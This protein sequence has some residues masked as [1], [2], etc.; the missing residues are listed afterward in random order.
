M[1]PSAMER[2]AIDALAEEHDDGLVHAAP[3]VV[4]AI[5]KSEV[6]AQL[7]AAHKYP[8]SVTRFLREA[9]SLATVSQEVASS[10]LY[11]V[12][13]DGKTV[14]GPSVRLAE[15]CASAYGNLHVGGRIADVEDSD[16]V[17]QGVA[18]D[19]ERNLRVSVEVRRRII[20]RNKRR[21]SDDMITLTGNAAAS[22]ALRNAIFRVIPRA[23]VQQVYEAARRVAVGD[24][25]TLDAKRTEWFAYLQKMGINQDRVLTRL[26]KTGVQDI[27]LD[28]IA[29]LIGLANAVRQGEQ[30]VDETFPA[31]APPPVAAT[32]DGQRVK[33]E[34]AKTQP[35]PE[36]PEST[37]AGQ[38]TAT[39][40]TASTFD[41][42]PPGP[43]PR[44]P[45][46]EPGQEG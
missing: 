8:R 38:A 32:Q 15:I 1:N 23:Y 19:L 12:P 14:D 43:R 40:P 36:R 6:E 7:D 16:V 3:N 21:F 27:G 22:I 44:R 11:A 17:A 26:G 39:D 20:G 18:W 35:Q 41:A 42:P 31:V 29:V 28:D 37:P 10:C 25:K 34:S 2:T 9:A 13:R 24:A 5:A 4:A 33:P 45:M 46:R 30:T